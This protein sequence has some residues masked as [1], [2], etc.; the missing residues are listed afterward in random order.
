MYTKRKSNVT[1]V[2]ENNVSILE[3]P[4]DIT[5]L[6]NQKKITREYDEYN[7]T[8]CEILL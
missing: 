5:I 8:S 2:S 6:P 3:L 4:S 7:A 1:N